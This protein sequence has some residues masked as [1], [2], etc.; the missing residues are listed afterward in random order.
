[1]GDRDGISAEHAVKMF[2]QIPGSRLS[3]LPGC[4]HFVPFLAPER[5]LE[6]LIPFL[7]GKHYVPMQIGS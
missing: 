7:D 1:L 6:P 3:I 4:D 5:L 2:R